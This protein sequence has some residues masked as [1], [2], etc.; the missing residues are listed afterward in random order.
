MISSSFTSPRVA[1]HLP[2]PVPAST[3]PIAHTGP[4]GNHPSNETYESTSH[5]SYIS[6]QRDTHRFDAIHE[7]AHNKAKAH[8]P[9]E[10][11]SSGE[12]T[13]YV[14]S[15]KSTF[16][17]SPTRDAPNGGATKIP[18]IP[19]TAL[20]KSTNHHEQVIADTRAQQQHP[21]IHPY[22]YPPSIMHAVS[23]HG[24]GNSAALD[25]IQGSAAGGIA[26][27][28]SATGTTTATVPVTQGYNILNGSEMPAYARAKQPGTFFAGRVS[29]AKL[30]A[31]TNA[32]TSGYDIISHETHAGAAMGGRSTWGQHGHK[33]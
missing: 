17:G 6:H 2:W 18:P 12:K 7:Y 28:Q 23:V 5:S 29:A 1:E 8:Q 10:W 30:E 13:A 3:D 27:E 11:A 14:S 24:V 15:Y 33:Q 25:A 32:R 22:P 9:A 26:R 20:G 19:R 21:F 31:K 16:Q 4:A